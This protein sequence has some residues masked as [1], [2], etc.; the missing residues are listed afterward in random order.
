MPRPSP[1]DD[2][3]IAVQPAA[4]VLS[5]S[6]REVVSYDL[7]G[8]VRTWFVDGTAYKR[9]LASEVVARRSRAAPPSATAR[10]PRHRWALPAAEADALFA[11][12]AVLAE[13]AEESTDAVPAD[14][15]DALRA[16]LHEARA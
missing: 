7:E 10:G 5:P 6:R 9:S 11:R 3:R 14:A 13:A 1:P 16:R 12:A 4:T 15:R 2:W 8:R